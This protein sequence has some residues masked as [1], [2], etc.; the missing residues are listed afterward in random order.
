M[1]KRQILNETNCFNA[2]NACVYNQKNDQNADFLSVSN[3]PFVNAK[4]LGGGG[5]LVAKNSGYTTENDKYTCKI[6]QDNCQNLQ[7]SQ[8]CE[9][10]ENVQKN[11][12]LL[13]L[14]KNK[15]QI[16]LKHSYKNVISYKNDT[17]YKSNTKTRSATTKLCLWLFLLVA[18]LAF[19]VGFGYVN[20][21]NGNENLKV[22]PEI[23]TASA[24]GSTWSGSGTQDNPYKISTLADLSLLATNCNAGQ[25][26]SNTYF[27][28]TSNITITASSWV[29]IAVDF[30]TGSTQTNYFSGI[31]D[32]GAGENKT[33]TIDATAGSV[34]ANFTVSAQ[35]DEAAFGGLFG[36]VSNGEIKN[37]N[38]QYSIADYGI[39]SYTKSGECRGSV[40]GIVGAC[41]ASTISDCSISGGEIKIPY[42]GNNARFGGI[43]GRGIG[44][45]TVKN[46]IMNSDIFTSSTSGLGCS[47]GLG[48]MGGIVAELE[49]TISHCEVKSNFVSDGNSG[50]LLS[51]PAVGAVAGKATNVDNCTFSGNKITIV[52][53]YIERCGGIVGSATNVTNCKV[54][55]KNDGNTEKIKM[56]VNMED[57]SAFCGVI[58]GVA[59]YI[60]NCYID[61]NIEEIYC[62]YFDGVSCGG[63]VAGRA[64][65]IKNCFANVTMDN[66]YVPRLCV[67]GFI[68]GG[69]VTI[70]SDMGTITPTV[71]NCFVDVEIAAK[72]GSYIYAITSWAS[73]YGDWADEEFNVYNCVVITSGAGGSAAF[74]LTGSNDAVTDP[75]NGLYSLTLTDAN[76][77]ELKSETTYTSGSAHFTWSSN[78]SYK[79]DFENTWVIKSTM[80][81]GYPTLQMLMTSYNITLSVTTNLSCSTSGTT[82]GTS[83]SSS[84]SSLADQ[85]IIYRLD[86]SGSLVNQ[87]VVRNGSTVTFE[88]DKNKSFTILIN[89]KLYMVTTIGTESTNKKTFTPTA[90]TTIN[91]SIT[92]P[93]GVNNWIV[94]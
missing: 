87:F 23:E 65:V 7:S 37:I 68:A 26:Y 93:A 88:A 85:F 70:T 24:E 50:R 39:F 43:V 69:L 10:R 94:I 33:I 64:T 56:R 61:A 91:I 55:N 40:G 17:S 16:P 53:S 9:K 78:T 52:S 4:K 1:I 35:T 71:S 72:S 15:K 82:T 20:G 28:V 54:I 32:G 81:D 46:C 90:D 76:L 12:N 47:S 45:S 19:A 25:H 49:G 11:D 13:T 63:L 31:F 38:L 44:N 77:S 48:Y 34:P 74:S 83:G 5:Y 66:V 89:H 21:S 22:A 86:E 2:E 29:P 80:N 57:Y 36:Y 30:T 67:F 6:L 51:V 59:Q 84:T 75:T 60:E 41:N 58:S 18:C 3:A 27:K 8:N 73:P 62:S 79:W 14:S 92:A 42:W